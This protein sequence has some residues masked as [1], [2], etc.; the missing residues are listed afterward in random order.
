MRKY[1]IYATQIQNNPANEPS[2][3]GEVLA[4]SEKKA[5]SAGYI[6]FS[7]LLAMYWRESLFAVPM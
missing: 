4:T 5:V 6:E 3:L 1:L 2:L 7:H